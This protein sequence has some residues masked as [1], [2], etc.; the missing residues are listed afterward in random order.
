MPLDP[1]AARTDLTTRECAKIIGGTLGGLVGMTQDAEVRD[2]IRWWASLSD[3][4]WAEVIKMMRSAAQ[5]T[6][7]FIGKK[8]LH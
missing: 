2:A 7:T 6:S 1:H 3:E 8:G 4:Q 5:G